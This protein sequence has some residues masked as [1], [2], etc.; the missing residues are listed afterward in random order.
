[1]AMATVVAHIVGESG[2]EA[3]AEMRTEHAR[4]VHRMTGERDDAIGAFRQV[5]RQRVAVLAQLVAVEDELSAALVG[6]RTRQGCE[7]ELRVALASA[8]NEN[9]WVASELEHVQ[10][11]ASRLASELAAVTATRDE[12]MAGRED[13][14][15]RH[16]QVVDRERQAR[17]DSALLRSELGLVANTVSGELRAAATSANAERALAVRETQVEC[18]REIADLRSQVDRLT[19]D[20]SGGEPPTALIVARR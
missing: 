17:E 18:R 2:A 7:E 9:R 16:E 15:R 14:V 19:R 4:I 3:V 10:A 1:M 6:A 5:E 11:Q 13:L 12:A 20:G 8:A